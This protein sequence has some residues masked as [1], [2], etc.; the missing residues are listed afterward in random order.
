MSVVFGVLLI[1]VAIVAAV[2]HQQK[3]REQAAALSVSLG[4]R[5]QEDGW[6]STT[7]F[8]GQLD[9]HLVELVLLTRTSGKSSNP[10]TQ[11][12][13]FGA[14]PMVTLSPQ[15]LGVELWQ[16]VAGG[17]DLRVGDPEFDAAVVVRGDPATLHG[18]LDADTR[19]EVLRLIGKKGR[20]HE[21]KLG[22]EVSGHQTDP[23]VVRAELARLGELGKALGRSDAARLATN[24]VH[25][26]E[27]GVRWRC[28]EALGALDAARASTTAEAL[29][30]DPD[31]LVRFAAARIRRDLD[32][33]QEASVDVKLAAAEGDP[34]GVARLLLLAGDEAG[35]VGLLVGTAPVRVAA[36]DALAR[37]GTVHAVEP[38]LPL[39][40]ALLGDGETKRAAAAAIEAIQGRV[41]HGGHGT[42]S[43]A[44]EGGRVSVDERGAVSLAKPRTSG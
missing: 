12:H 40:R 3:Q 6:R 28:L 30:N 24:A 20:V 22:Y 8:S 9:G 27:P 5:A 39:A 2:V 37:I 38:L 33:L 34:K 36:C 15:N 17:E 11:F 42:L 13:A 25:D 10:Y 21:G 23:A 44:D 43:V 4:L 16:A 14:H 29:R 19:R 26:P 32:A 18:L 41:A 31:A 7:T 35:L 1:V